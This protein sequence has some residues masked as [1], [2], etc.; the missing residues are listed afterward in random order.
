MAASC[1][2]S[3]SELRGIATIPDILALLHLDQIGDLGNNVR[4]LAALPKGVVVQGCVQALQS[5]GEAFSAVQAAHVGLIWRTSR[6]LVHEWAGLSEADFVDID[7]WAPEEADKGNTGATTAA[8]ATAPVKD[9]VLK[10][11]NIM[12]QADDSELV[13]A[14][15]ADIDMWVNRYISLMGSAPLEEEEPNEA[16]LSAMHR[17]V[18]ILHQPPYADFAVWLPCGRRTYKAQRFRSYM[19]VGDGTYALRE[20]PGPQN[21]LQWQC[22]W[23][24]Y[25]VAMLML[26]ICSLASLSLYER[27]IDKLV[28]Q[29]PKCWHLIVLAEDKARAERLEHIRRRLVR[30]AANGIPTPADFLQNEPWTACFR[31]LSLDDDYWSEQVCHPAAAW[32]ANGA[33]GALLAPAEQIAMSHFPGGID[34]LEADKEEGGPKKRQSNRDKRLAKA[35]RQRAEREELDRLRRGQSGPSSSVGGGQPHGKGKSKGKSKDQA[36]AQ[37]CYSFAN[38]NEPRRNLEPGAPCVQTPKRAHKCQY[39]FSPG[40]RNAD[41]PK[42]V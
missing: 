32:V 29:W 16:Q 42:K 25:K 35:K 22:S 36:G 8:P 2:P 19:P 6:R 21:L 3:V 33:K 24:V 14:S 4:V 17:R 28:M 9:R 1:L 12:D 11:A 34:S 10:M 38:G 27:T 20:L 41:C 23:K 37:I 13:P 40:H 18:F 7:P 26:G 31:L 30:D 15:K 5:S 39:C